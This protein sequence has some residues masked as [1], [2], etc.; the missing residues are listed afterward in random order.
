MKQNKLII[1]LIGTT[2]SGKSTMIYNIKE[3]LRTY[4]YNIE[5]VPDGKEF[6]NEKEF[7]EKIEKLANNEDFGISL[8]RQTITIQEFQVNRNSIINAPSKIK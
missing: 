4:G 5:Y 1:G 6:K 3:I 2:G 7:D 8:K